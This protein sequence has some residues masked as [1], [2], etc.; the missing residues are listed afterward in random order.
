LAKNNIK[1]LIN[2]EIREIIVVFTRAPIVI[3]LKEV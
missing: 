3:Y 1:Q 2:N